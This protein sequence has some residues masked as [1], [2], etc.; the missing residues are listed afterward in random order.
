MAG[1]SNLPVI[2]VSLAIDPPVY[3]RKTDGTFPILTVEA[4]LDAPKPIITICTWHTILNPRQ[5]LQQRGFEIIDKSTNSSVPQVAKK[6]KRPAIQPQYGTPDEQLF[7]T[8]VPQVP[9]KVETQFGP[10]HGET[11]DAG[12]Q[13]VYGIRALKEGEYSLRVGEGNQSCQIDCWRYGTK[14]ENLRPA[15]TEGVVCAPIQSENPIL[16][17]ANTINSADF[18]VE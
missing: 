2:S 15:D 11:E 10:P 14:E 9:H 3:N 4:V 5:A 1:T 7:I 8:L 12:E 16:I 6:N 17:D 18:V 13:P